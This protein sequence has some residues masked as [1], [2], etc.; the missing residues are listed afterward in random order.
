MSDSNNGRF[1]VVGLGLMGSRMA[2]KLIDGGFELRGF[3]VDPDRCAKAVEIGVEIAGSV[4][5][6]GIRYADATVSGNGEVAERGELVV[7]VGGDRESHERGEISSPH[8]EPRPQS[9]SSPSCGRGTA[10]A[11][12]ARV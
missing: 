6:V 2:R 9:R 1:A 12:S 4:D 11:R 3:D 7:M 10:P 5:E 8:G